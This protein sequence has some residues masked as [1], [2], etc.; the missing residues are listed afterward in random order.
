MRCYE[1]VFGYGVLLSLWLVT[2]SV[3]GGQPLRV[4]LD[5]DINSDNDDV[6]AVA[7]LHA[8]ADDGKVDI[9]AMGAVSRCPY[10]PA[11]LDAINTYYGRGDI[12]IGTYKGNEKGPRS[13]SRYAKAVAQQ[14]PN[15]MGLA[16]QVPDVIMIYRSVLAQQPDQTVTMIAVGQTNNLV[17]L[18]HSSPD[19]FSRLGGRDL[20]RKKVKTLFVM[21]P[22]FNERNTYQRAFNFTTAPKVAVELVATWPTPIKFGE[23]NLG[24][25]HYI[26]TR[27]NETPARNPTRIAFETYNQG[28]GKGK[29]CSNRHCADPSTVL[30]AVHGTRYFG[31]VGPG[32]C[33]VR[34]GDAFTRWDAKTDKQHFYNTQ[35]LPIS[36]L[37][38]IMED[39]L[40]QPPKAG[41]VPD[42]R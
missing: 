5:T 16:D 10:S 18:L 9:L 32:A 36:E 41:R 14:C 3:I 24:H 25:R 22:Y 26:G 34:V 29:R 2:G 23:G 21:A 11:C 27:L 35:K 37:E 15:N 6:A 12:P 8:M 7:M 30:Y 38:K 42:T 4:I 17:N 39:L 31:E 19:A 20:V 33:D 28:A 1:R 13:K 40:V